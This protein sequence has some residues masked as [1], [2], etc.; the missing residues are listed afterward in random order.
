MSITK[1]VPPPFTTSEADDAAFL[2][3]VQQLLD[4]PDLTRDAKLAAF[5]LADPA[6]QREFLARHAVAAR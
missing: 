6:A 2:A 4:D 5:G 1:P 3:A